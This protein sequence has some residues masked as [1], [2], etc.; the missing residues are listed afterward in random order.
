MPTVRQLA[1]TIGAP[2]GR[3]IPLPTIQ[4]QPRK[5]FVLVKT[6]TSAIEYI[7]A[8]ARPGEV[9][10]VTDADYYNPYLWHSYEDCQ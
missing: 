6:H 8:T 9:I 5:P 4:A 1:D 10:H 3:G 2:T 7:V